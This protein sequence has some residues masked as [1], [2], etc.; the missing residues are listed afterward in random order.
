M[1]EMHPRSILKTIEHCLNNVLGSSYGI[2]CPFNHSGDRANFR[3]LGEQCSL[4]VYIEK[5]KY[6]VDLVTGDVDGAYE[7]GLPE[8]VGE[9]VKEFVEMILPIF[10]GKKPEGLAKRRIA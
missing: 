7:L 9:G 3:A 4:R 6:R 5:G 1:V 10:K 2:R 8:K